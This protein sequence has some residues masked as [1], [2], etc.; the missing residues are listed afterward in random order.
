M[1][2]PSGLF[3][4][5]F[6]IKILYAFSV[7]PSLASYQTHPWLHCHDSTWWPACVMMFL[8]PSTQC[9]V[10]EEQNFQLHC[11]KTSKLVNMEQFVIFFIVLN[12]V[13]DNNV[14]QQQIA[15]YC[16]RLWYVCY[17][18]VGSLAWTKTN[19]DFIKFL[20]RS[21]FKYNTCDLTFNF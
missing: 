13:L 7:S 8:W 19:F 17:I 18:S 9:H 4:R 6:F 16:N 5:G 10:P 1:L 21:L 14:C 2:L 20:L 11:F 3:S 12:E 15:K